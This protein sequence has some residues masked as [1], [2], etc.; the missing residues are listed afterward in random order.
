[1]N[2]D[3]ARVPARWAM[4]LLASRSRLRASLGRRMDPARLRRLALGIVLVTLLAVW[5]LRPARS[6]AVAGKLDARQAALVDEFLK[7][8]AAG[9]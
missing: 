1:M 8:E 7:L 4:R 5:W 3:R 9:L 6:P 2:A